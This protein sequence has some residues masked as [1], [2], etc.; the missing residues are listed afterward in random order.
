MLFFALVAPPVG[1]ARVQ[2][3]SSSDSVAPPSYT[4]RL[5][6]AMAMRHFPWFHFHMQGVGVYEPG[7]SYV[8]HF[9][10]IPWF[11]PH[12]KQDADLSMIDPQMWAKRYTYDIIGQHGDETLYA[13]HAI[14][15][16]SLRDATVAVGPDGSARRVDATYSDGTHITT[17]LTSSNVDGF[18][19]PVTM[20]AD[21]DEPHIALSANA[22][23]KDYTFGED[24]QSQ[25][26]SR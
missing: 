25:S 12:S 13:L 8:V 3:P 22:D 21:I 7:V 2:S 10:S 14:N 26:L 19:L 17:T 15:D 9:T 4:F 23:F 1:F 20:D 16:Q 6:V 18:V 11:I 24:S 5:D